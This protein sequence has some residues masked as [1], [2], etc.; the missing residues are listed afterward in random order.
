MEHSTFYVKWNKSESSRTKWIFE[1]SWTKNTTNLQVYKIEWGS[2]LKY[3]NQ[4]S[5]N[6]AKIG[7]SIKK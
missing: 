5:K 3:Q 6:W 2:K 4:A 7:D 1:N